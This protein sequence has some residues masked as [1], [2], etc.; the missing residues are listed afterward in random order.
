MSLPGRT[1]GALA[2]LVICAAPTLAGPPGSSTIEVSVVT[3]GAEPIAPADL[4]ATVR[5]QLTAIAAPAGAIHLVVS[6]DGV[7]LDV[8]GRHRWVAIDDWQDPLAVRTVV[9]HAVDLAQTAVLADLPPPAPVIVREIP[10][11]SPGAADLIVTAR[12]GHGGTSTDPT[13]L[14]VRGEAAIAR[15]AWRLGAGVGWDRGLRRHAGTPEDAAYDEWPVALIA[16]ARLGHVELAA[17]AQ[18]APYLISGRESFTGARVGAGAS[19]RARFAVGGATVIAEAGADA[20]QKRTTLTAGG[21]TRFST[22]RLAPYLAIGLAWS[23]TP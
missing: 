3:V 20:W 5:A 14:G 11:A 1:I 9:L 21:T 7:D 15:G 10:A 12:A 18:V 8:D 13:I 2:A 17:R 22:P 23:V 19:V 6:R 4:A 16:G